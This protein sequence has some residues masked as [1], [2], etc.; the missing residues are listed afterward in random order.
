MRGDNARADSRTHDRP[1][2]SADSR[3]HNRSTA[4]SQAQL[5]EGAFSVLVSDDVS[6]TLGPGVRAEGVDDLSV[7]MVAGAVGQNEIIRAQMDHR[8][9]VHA[10]ARSGVYHPAVQ[11]GTDRHHDFA[12][13]H[14]VLGDG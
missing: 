4:D 9:A 8:A 6:F 3:A 7:Q 10:I 12:V 13:A 11:L 1:D 14:D 2:S 5:G